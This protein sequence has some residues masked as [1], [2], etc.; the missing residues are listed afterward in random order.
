MD[1]FYHYPSITIKVSVEIVD[2]GFFDHVNIGSEDL[3]GLCSGPLS[4]LAVSIT[5]EPMHP[6][7][8]PTGLTCWVASHGSKHGCTLRLPASLLRDI[9]QPSLGNITCRI[10]LVSPLPLTKVGLSARTDKGYEFASSNPTLFK[11]WLL[12]KKPILRDG[13]TYRLP[14]PRHDPDISDAF[15]E[16][17]MIFSEPVAQGYALSSITEISVSLCHD[18]QSGQHVAGKVEAVYEDEIIEIDQNFMANSVLPTIDSNTTSRKCILS[19]V[20]RTRN[21]VSPP[22][23]YTVLLKPSDLSKVGLISGDWAII[24]AA[25]IKTRRV[26]K[27]VAWQGVLSERGEVVGDPAF[28]HNLGATPLRSDVRSVFI[29]VSPFGSLPPPLPTARSVTVAQIVSPPGLNNSYGPSLLGGLRKYFQTSLRLVKRGD[30]LIV[31]IETDPLSIHI[32]TALGDIPHVFDGNLEHPIGSALERNLFFLVTNIEY[33]VVPAHQTTT[34][35]IYTGA[36]AGE[37]GCWVD[38]QNT[39]ILQAGTEQSGIPGCW[40]N[41]PLRVPHHPTTIKG[42]VYW[43][44]Y[45]IFQV[46]L[47]HS[48]PSYDL[49]VSVLLTGSRGVGKST[50][51]KTMA[52]CLGIHLFEVDCYTLL[53]ENSTRTENSLR[54]VFSQATDFSPCVLLLRHLEAFMHI[55]QQPDPIQEPRIARVLQEC[56]D[57]LLQSWRLTGYPLVVVGTTGTAQECSPGFLGCFKHEISIESPDELLRTRIWSVCLD[58]KFLASDVD[59]SRLA[60]HTAGLLASDV[61]SLVRRATSRSLER[62]LRVL[63]SLDSGLAYPTSLDSRGIIGGH[64]PLSDEDLTSALDTARSSY[65]E[66]IGAPKIPNVTW[67]DVGGL[68]SIKS[69]IL[70]T[71][72]LP[73]ERPE[74]FADGLKKRSGILLYG[75]PGTGKTLLAKAVATSCSLNFLSVKG[76]EVL[77]MYIGESEANVRRIFQRARA[78]RPCVIFFDE[79]DSVAPKRGNHGDSG[80]VMD[81]IVSQ[82]LSELDGMST[83]TGHTDVFVIGATNRPDLLDPALLRPGR[84]DRML[85]LGVPDSNEAQMNVVR[86]LTRKFRLHPA[87]S[88][89]EVVSKCPFHFTG[90][91]FYALCS[92][93]ML[94]A[95]SRRAGQVEKTIALLNQGQPSNHPYP[96]TPHYY[97]SEMALERDVRV[98]VTQRDFDLALSQLKP[99]ITESEMQH[100]AYIQRLFSSDI[101]SRAHTDVE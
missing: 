96:I 66:A 79:L 51:V 61:G 64:L 91:D 50:M 68:S 48:A 59:M 73:L 17:S 43:R 62:T 2:D 58:G 29:T 27:V 70:D 18:T 44:L 69:D 31:P 5:P 86:A 22:N 80:G 84:F 101:L 20:D 65:A 77:N 12:S 16:Y 47:M 76:P 1:F 100:Y 39:R 75:P 11:T 21:G 92:D 93:A 24:C 55:T 28:L 71:I 90:A 13:F 89:P 35:D 41:A 83:G 45:R 10:S 32:A 98:L 19:L 99:S 56:L 54:G 74:L 67:E 82:L 30:I 63:Q 60:V 95:M 87:L 94:M 46:A 4:D 26:V 40:D 42:N 25:D 53:Q 15:H 14:S 97:L 7:F 34:P 8:P 6:A 36:S 49:A 78:A 23:E 3:K 37:L 88:L 33:D 57:G 85:Y 72:Q 9:E 81:R 38:C 52:N